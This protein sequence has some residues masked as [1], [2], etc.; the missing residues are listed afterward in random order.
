MKTKNII[1]ILILILFFNSI[2]LYKSSLHSEAN[3]LYTN[4]ELGDW[5][6][7]FTS[8]PT[9]RNWL[10]SSVINEKIYVIGGYNGS[11]LNNVEVYDPK[12]N[13]W[14]T[15]APLSIARRSLTSSVIDGKLY[16]V[17]GYN[18]KEL[19]TLEVYDPTTNTWET[20]A[21]MPTSRGYQLQSEA[22]NGK[23]YVIGGSESYTNKVEMYDPV[24]NKWETKSPMPTGRGYFTTSV[25]NNKIY[26]IGGFNGN[27]IL[28]KLEVYDPATDTWETKANMPTS[29]GYLTSSVMDNLIYVIGGANENNNIKT[30]TVEM[31]N[32]ATDTW[33]TKTRMP[34]PT[35]YLT[36][37]TVG[38]KIFV[39]GGGNSSG[40]SN[41]VQ[42]FLKITNEQIAENAVTRAEISKSIED[43]EFARDSVN[44]LPESET[45]NLLQERLNA[46]FLQ[47]SLECKDT[48]AN[49]DIYIKS[50]NMLSLSLDTNN[51]VFDS[52][53]G[54][55]DIEK[56]KAI[57]LT[58]NSSLAYKIKAYLPIEIQ[59]ADKSETLD[60]SVLNI[61]V[62]TESNYQTFRD[63]VTPIVLLD[64]HVS[65]NNIKHGI[66]LKLKSNDNSHKA[67]IYKTT[68]KFEIEQQ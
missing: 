46:L 58:V 65:G 8:M 19:N 17:G 49:L 13:S 32:P 35:S 63:L 31:Y 27:S 43:V 18:G 47:I 40:Y 48:T 44:K 2:S 62:D 9:A 26:C 55:E 4:E 51:V 66:D 30:S 52:F 5:L 1:L 15:K 67:D 57:S 24:T 23:L 6:T 20:K 64:Y 61:K 36:S 56:Q 60:K 28:N 33:E 68:I 10:T 54:I 34:T 3:S 37:E 21:N 42:A 53:S 11:Y 25:V 39:I 16:V 14:E 7:G 45:K 12:T 50:E 22:V 38:D 59:N 29:R 41:K